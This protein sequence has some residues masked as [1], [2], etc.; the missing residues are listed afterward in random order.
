MTFSLTMPQYTPDRVYFFTSFS[1]FDFFFVCVRIV[2]FGFVICGEI[3][4]KKYY[5]NEDTE[6][7]IL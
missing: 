7:D 2:R 4:R 6:R 5:S 1:F 3:A